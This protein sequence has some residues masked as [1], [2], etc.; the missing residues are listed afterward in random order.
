MYKRYMD[1]M[2]PHFLLLQGNEEFL[3]NRPELRKPM[4]SPFPS[5]SKLSPRDSNQGGVKS[6]LSARVSP[7]HAAAT[8][9][10]QQQNTRVQRHAKNDRGDGPPPDPGYK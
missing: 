6:R 1:L 5:T 9:Q 8:N 10:Q 3:G 4:E 2:K 7:N